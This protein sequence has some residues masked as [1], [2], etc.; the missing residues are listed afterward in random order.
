MIVADR[1]ATALNNR[2]P[3][4]NFG[5]S[6]LPFWL[7]WGGP[8]VVLP[9]LNVLRLPLRWTAGVFAVC[10][11]WMGVGCAINARR[12]RRRHCYYSSPVLLVGALLTLL[13]GFGHL[14]FGPDG[15]MYV[16]W[17]T[18]VGVL[19]TFLPERLFGKYKS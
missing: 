19:L 16:T 5:S 12:C 8:I 10:F 14:D 6:P 3:E 4:K 15:F 9:S 1:D 17:G 7:L 2:I 13:V 11:V 18:F